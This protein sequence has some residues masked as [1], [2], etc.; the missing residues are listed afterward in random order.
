MPKVRGG[1][2][3]ARRLRGKQTQEQNAETTKCCVPHCGNDVILL[4]PCGHAHCGPCVLGLLKGTCGDTIYASCSQCREQ[5]ELDS[6]GPVSGPLKH[7]FADFVPS[8]SKTV[9]ACC[10]TTLVVAHL[11]C[12]CGCYACIDSRIRI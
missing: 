2:Q 10:S 11:P 8:H 5:Y 1:K 6:D 12:E 9:D 7:L 4:F 3:A